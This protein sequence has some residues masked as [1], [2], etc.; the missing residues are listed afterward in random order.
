MYEKLQTSEAYISKTLDVN[1]MK[2]GRVI[3][4]P[5]SFTFQK[6][7]PAAPNLHNIFIK[8]WTGTRE[9]FNFYQNRTRRMLTNRMA[10]QKH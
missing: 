7:G 6:F 2:F 10:S 4:M 8:I 1:D 3:K 9:V 5:F